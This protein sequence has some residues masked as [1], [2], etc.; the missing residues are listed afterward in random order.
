MPIYQTRVVGLYRPTDSRVDL[1]LRSGSSIRSGPSR[2]VF[3]RSSSWLMQPIQARLSLHLNTTRWRAIGRRTGTNNHRG[4]LDGARKAAVGKPSTTATKYGRGTI[5]SKD[6]HLVR[7]RERPIAKSGGSRHIRHTRRKLGARA[8]RRMFNGK[9]DRHA[10]P[11][12]IGVP[13]VVH[14][15]SEPERSQEP[16]K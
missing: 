6:G 11:C 15:R 7:R 8:T 16:D 2:S 13:G 12:P 1:I 5:R 10:R 14:G 4:A 9:W 3:I